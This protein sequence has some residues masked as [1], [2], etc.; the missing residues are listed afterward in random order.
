MTHET[1]LDRLQREYRENGGCCLR[2]VVSP[3]WI[4][5]LR[6]AFAESRAAP[7]SLSKT[8]RAEAGPGCFFQDVFVW[9]R[10]AELRRFALESGIARAVATLL[11]AR[12]LRL[13]SDHVF[14]RDVGTEKDTPWHQDESY[15]FV[16]G[17]QFCSVWLPLDAVSQHECLQLVRGSH[18]DSPLYSPVEFASRS[19]Y[20]GA[21]AAGAALPSLDA[22]P[23]SSPDILSWDMRLGDCLVF[24]A[25][26]LHGSTAHPAA[27]G[28][29]RAY[30]TRWIGDD[31]RYTE[32]A[33][34]VPALPRPTGL[35]R[36]DPFSGELFPLAYAA[37]G[38]TG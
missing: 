38:A 14:M 11:G 34:T 10:V 29:R 33:W 31:A 4:E 15:C 35:R 32:Q 7:S 23:R 9:R 5:R 17:S 30:V 8:W 27:T 2:S 6:G 13:Y 37:G 26:T 20:A 16:T 36:G 3:P 1:S 19:A 28:P 18:R 22:G 24:S 25:R 21:A 12:E